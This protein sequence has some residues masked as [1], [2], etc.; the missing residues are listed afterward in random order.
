MKSIEELLSTLRRKGIHL[1]VENQQL[2]FDAPKAALSE[3]EIAQ[4]RLHKPAIIAYL[5]K[6][7]AGS[8]LP[9]LR[10]QPRSGDIPLSFAQERLWFLDRLG[11][12]G[13]AYH[14][15]L[16]LRLRGR[17]NRAALQSS[18]AELQRRHESLRTRFEERDGNAVQ[19]VEQADD[20]VLAFTDLS[21]LGVQE[22]EAKLHDL[23]THSVYEPFDL[24][25]GF[26][27]RADLLKIADDEH[28]LML[29]MHHIASDGWSMEVLARELTAL[30][31]AH[32]QGQRAN[33]PELPV[34]YA[35]YALWQRQYM[36]GDHLQGQ[37]NYWRNQLTGAPEVLDLPLDRPR[38]ATESFDGATLRF[39]VSK[40][41]ASA[42]AHLGREESATSFI[43]LLA[44]FQ[45]LLSRWSG[46][47][48]VV[49]GSPIAGRTHRETENLIGF[50]V[51]TLVFRTVLKDDESFRSLLRRVK[52]MALE[53]YAH[54]DL[55]FTRL[56]ADLQPQRNLSHQP[57][58]QTAFAVQNSA[59][60]RLELKGMELSRVELARVMA[61]FDLLLVMGEGAEE[62]QGAFEYA[63]DLFDHD[64]IERLAGYLQNLLAQIAADPDAPIAQLS[65]LSATQ[66]QVMYEWSRG[67]VPSLHEQDQQ[68]RCFHHLFAEQAAR[69]P[70]ALA[71]VCGTQQL[72]YRELDQRSNRLATYL[73]T[74]GVETEV[75]VGL[76][77]ERS[78]DTLIGLLGILKA[79]GV[80]LPLDA[81]QPVERI[82]YML[83]DAG[84]A[85][86]L[87]H[88]ALGDALPTHWAR[89]VH[90]DA[91]AGE[92][93]RQPDAAPASTAIADNLAY[94]IYT[95]GSTGQP[96]AAMLAHRGLCNLAQAQAS[97]FGVR[98]GSRVL[99]F[100]RLGFDASISEIAMTLSCG[101][102]LY[103]NPAS[104]LYS[105]AQLARG[106]AD[107]AISVVTL[108]PSA[109]TLLEDTPLPQLETL[110][111]AGE[112]CAPELAAR[113][114]ARCRL[115]NAY[116]PTE[117]TVCAS[118][119][120]CAPDARQMSIGRAMAN[121]QLHVLDERLEPVPVGVA[122]ELYIGGMGLAR[123]YV[124]RPGLTAQRF[125]AHPRE[126]GA[127]LYRSGDRVRWLADGNLEFMG[128]L[129][130]QVKIR[131]HRVEPGE[132]E[133]CLSRHPR[134]RQAVVIAREDE[135]GRKR[136][137]AYLVPTQQPAQPD[138]YTLPN[139]LRV[140]Q[141]NPHETRALYKE[142][143]Q[144]NVYLTDGIEL[145]DHCVVFDV[146]ANIGLF[147]LFVNHHYA[148]ARVYAF[149]PVTPVFERLRENIAQYDL[150]AQAFP[151]ALS[152]HAGTADIHFYPRMSGNS[153]L[154]AD[155]A[156][157][158]AVTATFLKNVLAEQHDKVDEL[159]AGKFDSQVQRCELR[160][161]SQM[162]A[163]LAVER[164]DL[165]KID[166]EKSEWDV[167]A[168]IE[169]GDWAKIRQI[170]LEVH[171]LDD[172]V[173]RIRVLLD[174]HGFHC[175]V[176]QR[177]ELAGTGL[178]QIHAVNR[179]LA[180]RAAMRTPMHSRALLTS[181]PVLDE[182]QLVQDVQ[183]Q[184]QRVLPDYMVPAAF[185]VLPE[186]PLTANGKI[187]RK[188]LPRPETVNGV[189]HKYLAPA[190]GPQTTLANIWMQL[191]KLER[192]GIHD[193]FFELGG[194]SI[195]AIQMIARANRQGLKLAL[196]QIFD[197]QT[198]AALAAVAGS[199]EEL[200]AEQDAVQGQI[201]LTPIQRW[202][203]EC[204]HAQPHHFN[205]ALLLECRSHL[206]ETLLVDALHRLAAHH[207]ML[208]ARF[209]HAGP[210]WQQAVEPDE[211]SVLLDCFDLSS[212]PLDE[213][214][215]ELTRIAAQQQASLDLSN[216]PLV[217]AALFEMGSQ[218]LQ[219]LLIVIHH[220]IVDTVSWRIL[221]EDLQS[222]CEHTSH[223][224]PLRLPAKS[225]SF[226][227]W[228]ERLAAFATTDEAHREI[229]YWQAL[230][231]MQCTPLP[232]D[233]LSDLGTVESESIV[234]ASLS[235]ADTA[236]LLQDV[237]GVYRTQINE[238]LLTALAQTFAAWTG[239]RLMAVNL[240]G[241][242]RE[243]LFEDINLSRTVGWF[244][245]AFPI[246]IDIT[247]AFDPG[248]ALR[249]VKEQLRQVPH[250]GVGY[251]V[252]RYLGGMAGLPVPQVGFNYLGQFDRNLDAAALFAP[253][254]E[255]AGAAL[256]PTC[257]RQHV[258]DIVC[259]VVEGQ[260]QLRW[261]YNGA[262]YHANT[263]Q[264]LADQFA[265]QLRQIIVHCQGSEGGY[266]P[267]DFPLAQLD[268]SQLD[269]VVAV[270]GG[271]RN[272]EDMY[273][274]S[275]LQHGMLF[276]SLHA[277]Q[278]TAYCNTL[279]W[280]FSG[281]LN[282]PAL[283]RAW[284]HVVD[285][286]AVLRTAF[287]VQELA[288]PLQVVLR[289]AR[290]P[291]TQ[292][293]WRG[294][295]LVEQEQRLQHLIQ[296]DRELGFD[297]LQP[298]LM[299]MTLVRTGEAEYRLVWSS[300]HALFDGWSVPIL[301]NEVFASYLAFVRDEQPTLAAAR[302]YRDYIAWLQ[303]QDGD[304]TQAYWRE[305]L[306]GFSAA[307]PLGIGA[308]VSAAAGTMSVA[309]LSHEVP[310][311][312][313]AMEQFAREHKLTLNT[314][315][316]AA[317]AMVLSR[318][319]GREDVLFGVTLA[320][321][322]VELDDAENR[323]GLF[324]NTLPLR[325]AVDR[326]Q[327]VADFLQHLQ[328][329]QMELFEQQHSSLAQ[330]R[331]CSTV[332]PG[333]ALFESLLVF[334]NY[335]SE[336]STAGRMM[337]AV[338]IDDV[339]AMER[340]HYPLTLVCGAKR[341]LSL[342][343]LYDA[344]RFDAAAID[345]LAG[346]FAQALNAM[347]ADPQTSLR[348]L[349]ILTPMERRAMQA[350][351]ATARVYP[352]HQC[353]PAL[354]AEQAA[355]RP[356]AVALASLDRQITYGELERRSNRLARTL[357]G[358][359][360]GSETVV[361]LCVRPSV[362]MAVGLLGI[363]KAGGAY[364][365]LDPAYP[366]E[367]LTYLLSDANVSVVLGQRE[368][369]E[370][371]DASDRHLVPLDDD[372]D[373]DFP[374]D[375]SFENAIDP[376]NL[377]YVTYTSGSTGRPK[378][379]AVT[380]Q[381][382]IRLVKGTNYIHLSDADTVLQ[383]APLAFDA[384]TFELWGAWLNGGT[385]LIVDRD[386]A[387]SGTSL[388][389]VLRERKVSAL[390]VTTALFNRVVQEEP[391]VFASVHNVLV[392]GD[393]VDPSI[394]RGVLQHGRPQRLLN[395]Y[396]PTE[397][398]TFSTW[399]EINDVAPD[400]VAV[401]IG[402]P[403]ANGGCYVLD[404]DFQPLPI[405]VAGEL[406]ITGAGLA[407]GYLNRPGLT[408][409]R[410]V[411]DPFVAGERMYRTGDYARYL[412]DGN[413]Q[414][415]GRVDGQVKIR[416]HRIE[417]GEIEV[418]LLANHGVREAVVVAR[419]EDGDKR[420]IAYLVRDPSAPDCAALR[421]SLAR[422]L[423]DYMLPAAFV[424][425]PS[426]PLNVNGKIDRQA[427]PA[428][429]ASGLRQPPRVAPS[430]SLELT[431]AAIWSDVLRLDSFGVDDN[432]FELG[433]H[434]LSAMRVRVHV[435]KTLGVELELRILFEQPTIAQLARYI[436]QREHQQEAQLR[437]NLQQRI[438]HMSD[439]EV[440]TM[441]REMARNEESNDV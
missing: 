174:G 46:Q 64:S 121:V 356:D 317:W 283:M 380:H 326:T 419:E 275:A 8:T 146:G 274:P 195:I 400:A 68:D 13:A 318:Y 63:T 376:H 287:V 24:L 224:P 35:D 5:Q 301:L 411:A 72:T 182:A 226:K 390:F 332:A 293:D 345:R 40:D 329:R 10:A 152:N 433:G 328:S 134:L 60:E 106:L 327:P 142:I 85:V 165:L 141:I 159:V 307:T 109:L 49:V 371:I 440:A 162:L 208:R 375:D 221:L 379:V 110:I 197:F 441:L 427:L 48:D 56:V 360:V 194:D 80:Y 32:S 281:A 250:R 395:G 82:S 125:I 350:W 212:F 257:R 171:D 120:P 381:N 103:L 213:Q 57:I 2:L 421:E 89:V 365:A 364:L 437:S 70:E 253:A 22:R 101:A 20:R 164:L 368:T 432:F 417:P 357:V 336:V 377:A 149:E 123:G 343:V 403:L 273:P 176:T 228:A 295:S 388:R 323:V 261:S 424:E 173:Q 394:V 4:I 183:Q 302:P 337:D 431:L 73:Q 128:R 154:Y 398:T 385:V 369:L 215:G 114:A 27:L 349:A 330:L 124:N 206:T 361:G 61:R 399:Y 232:T 169:D 161:I 170:V 238:V 359:G 98:A 86:L 260:L 322:P 223:A 378:G 25:R 401:P 95:S 18:F 55:P 178:Y 214:A 135:P 404:E 300:H 297:F 418:A 264:R 105:A 220:L 222:L 84:V 78:L 150:D 100:A 367:R 335:P 256:S 93:D 334:E 67:G 407:R 416:G 271:S 386:T 276:H 439:Q 90:L 219:R 92:I 47:R 254:R 144:D 265:A 413:L 158:Q 387:L 79:G 290:L 239:Q 384:S 425:L 172:R 126:P 268:P 245:S 108:P 362:D 137:V 382:I 28:V 15:P 160:T 217:R 12:V 358:L 45:L 119:A 210:D 143:F 148:N 410:F 205:Q 279:S 393:A 200:V 209:T 74:L 189:Q 175:T 191:L 325:V 292:H 320:G 225:S 353:V 53:A 145:D 117:V 272:I 50:F 240:E 428:P 351:N 156:M 7:M 244:T 115:I 180:Q 342:R 81:D 111:V 207:D 168:G 83:D 291:W 77:V 211:S 187:D 319:S 138:A 201:P 231:W 270:V 402:K 435:R 132:I 118:Y 259:L 242:G 304:R 58:F 21:G 91:Q 373:E 43:V 409:Q 33:L 179:L 266:S 184:A 65:L 31:A 36:Q 54:Q 331:G 51:N 389:A 315:V 414:F 11:L 62:L 298:P 97:A 248:T 430:T 44:V 340:A 372:A 14:V 133:A 263:V 422:Q 309:E 192:V 199:V 294:T 333:D 243:D 87:T 131:G 338:R 299:R 96:K 193:N 406:Y 181:K 396:G 19:V 130:G 341:S 305:R 423:P 42:I 316:Q 151:Y 310:L 186:L 352:Q 66:R 282:V 237:P 267:I 153:S 155:P 296:A 420:L 269:A 313:A 247:S 277:T 344:G 234:T 39:S 52:D 415:I 99:Q 262:A 107:D 122:G 280:R 348:D 227:T 321:R 129:D 288:P 285:R 412:S 59:G 167:L 438:E 346:H 218:Q 75:V 127:R 1:M 139:G 436:E 258:F 355:R 113:W 306:A 429:Q 255:S 29:T 88:A 166:V 286:H 229:A 383:V 230:P 347:L 26:L 188:G 303:R 6:N 252:V 16:G 426:L 434:S 3:V 235:R 284:Q 76:Y 157:E 104:S 324:I 198:I 163:E 190:A 311:A 312:L 116:G 233:M 216:G 249:R 363:L 17:L 147:T 30:Y 391:Q 246:L 397:A 202:F 203:F 289:Q 308:A 370:K 236:A 185:V 23:L 41:V 136:L 204:G 251:G 9:S 366:H 38:P 405:G 102:M 278:S 408:A 140:A 177:P 374:L 69:M 314:L 241:H 94:V 339:H 71:A 392:G 34:Q 196:R 112:S 37:L 354:F